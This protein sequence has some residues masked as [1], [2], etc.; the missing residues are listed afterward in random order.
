M[1]M[2]L[3][4]TSF[5]KLIRHQQQLRRDG[6]AECPCDLRV[7]RELEL[8]WLFNG[9]IGGLR[10]LEDLV[11]VGRGAVAE[12]RQAGPIGHEPASLGEEPARVD[13][14]QSVLRRQVTYLPQVRVERL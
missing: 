14:R 2:G 3:P 9:K 4:I 11:H 1:R 5:H 13:T 10:A 12:G 6:E 8:R 7:D